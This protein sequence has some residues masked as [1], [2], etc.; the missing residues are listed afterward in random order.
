MKTIGMRF[1]VS[2]RKILIQFPLGDV[3]IVDV[4]TLWKDFK[5]MRN[6][7]TWQFTTF[8]SQKHKTRRRMKENWETSF[9]CLLYCMSPGRKFKEI[10]NW[11]VCYP[12]F[13]VSL[14]KLR[15]EQ[16]M[17][18]YMFIVIYHVHKTVEYVLWNIRTTKIWST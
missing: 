10:W 9:L 6:L 18:G 5:E 8:F 3:S 7:V 17:N 13:I 1:K 4:S 11:H 15:S 14:H 12:S 2:P 16:N